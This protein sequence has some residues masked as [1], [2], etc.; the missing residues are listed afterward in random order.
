MELRHLRYFIA[1]AEE[2]H[3]ARA[4]QRLHIEQSPLSRAIKDL[5]SD[6]NARL[7][8]R[9]TRHT[10][11]THAGHVLLGDARRI[12]NAVARARDNVRAAVEGRKAQL[13]VALADGVMQPRLATLLA[14]CRA[15]EPDISIRLV[16]TSFDEQL[17][18]L[19]DEVF[20]VGFAQCRDQSGLFEAEAV[21]NDPIMVALPAR[22]P[23]LAFKHIALADALRYPLVLLQRDSCPASQQQIDWMLHSVGA[24][25]VVA[26]RAATL[27]LMM[28]LISAGYGLG[29][30]SA[31]HM[32]AW[33][34]P[35]VVIRPLA[36]PA[37]VL[38]TY[39]LYPK[40]QPSAIRDRFIERAKQLH[41]VSL[42]LALPPN[43]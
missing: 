6:L 42:A 32:A 18:G 17:S 28:T 14:R 39:V 11:M 41:A 40:V 38:T 3:F 21:W 26:D 4:A 22:H 8:E 16:E 20:D 31:A 25:P 10:R 37:R 43:G 36:G 34:Y 30:L 13:A 5:E 15:E 23:L 12:M 35:D 24:P 1:V 33:Q 19:R 9:T 7:L 27:E 2:L 29:F